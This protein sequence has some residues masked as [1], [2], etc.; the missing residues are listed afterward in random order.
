MGVS[1]DVGDFLCA[2]G[3]SVDNQKEIAIE[4]AG[5]SRCRLGQALYLHMI[6]I[7]PRLRR[8]SDLGLFFRCVG[9]P[10]GGDHASSAFH[11]FFAVTVRFRLFLLAEFYAKVISFCLCLDKLRASVGFAAAFFYSYSI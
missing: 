4:T 1:P 7:K 3:S 8:C 2:R 6:A 10:F 11:E 5:S 9:L